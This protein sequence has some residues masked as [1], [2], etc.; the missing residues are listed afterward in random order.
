MSDETLLAKRRLR[1]TVREARRDRRLTDPDAAR[2]GFAAG[3]SAVAG[4][5][6]GAEVIAAYLAAPGEPDLGEALAAWHAEGVTVVVPL[7]RPGRVLDWVRFSPGLAVAVGRFAA[8]PEP[9]GA[10]SAAGLEPGLILVPALAVGADGTRLG[11]G[12]GFYDRYLD[13]ASGVSVGVVFDD[14]VL[15]EVP[16]QEWDAR[17]DAVWTPTG[18]RRLPR[19]P[20]T[21]QAV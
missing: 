1:S 15:P 9:V 8:V 19:E 18:V 21:G 2:E 3:R 13:G 4:L 10:V 11:Q 20:G 14:E 7:S 12:G 6:P 16:R 5:A 17:L